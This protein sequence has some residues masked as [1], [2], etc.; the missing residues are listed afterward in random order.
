MIEVI[1][2]V[3]AIRN[4]LSP[5]GR[6]FLLERL[7]KDDWTLYDLS[8][9]YALLRGNE[10]AL[11]RAGIEYEDI[12]IPQSVPWRRTLKQVDLYGMGLG[13][14]FQYDPDIVQ[15]V[16]DNLQGA[17]W[18]PEEKVWAFPITEPNVDYLLE[19]SRYD[20]ALTQD[21]LMAISAREEIIDFWV[22][23]SCATDAD[24]RLKPGFGLELLPF[25]RAGVKYAVNSKSCII[26]D[27]MGTGKTIQSLAAVHQLQAFPLI[28]VCPAS[29]KINWLREV[30]RALPSRTV[31][32]WSTTKPCPKTDVVVINY[33]ILKKKKKDLLSLNAQGI[34]F[35]E[36]HYLKNYKAQ[37]TKAAKEIAWKIRHKFALSGTPI[38]SRPIE[39]V[40][41]LSII[42]RLDHMGGFWPYLNNYCATYLDTPYLDPETGERQEIVYTGARNLEQL[43]RQLR[44]TCFVRRTKAEVLK[45]L[46]PKRITMVPLEVT[47]N[48]YRKLEDDFLYQIDEIEGNEEIPSNEKFSLSLTEI[49][50]LKQETLKLK[51]PL[52]YDWIDSVLES[53]EKLLVFVW[54]KLGAE[55]L[56]AKYD[57]PVI[58]GDTPMDKRQEYVDQFQTDP[59]SRM[60]VMSIKA[61]G[62]GLNLTAA[63][64]VAFLELGWTPADHEQAEDRA[65][66]IGQSNPVN[67]WYL[68]GANTVDE[69]V[70]N[71]LRNKQRIVSKATDGGMREVA[72]QV[73]SD[74]RKKR[75]KTTEAVQAKL[76]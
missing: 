36:S 3:K 11:Q 19:I 13:M 33:D 76:F 30:E 50:K 10:T 46:P 41:Q 44:G 18:V 67:V 54:H 74:M 70:W 69:M 62:V 29:L 63:S 9:A 37:R 21:A 49:S 15:E 31:S 58:N 6:A 8:V 23:A 47:E 73:I 40:S 24:I 34:I 7:N 55:L 4:D 51:M 56:K 12:E 20:T 2:A 38:L 59:G 22:Q 71:V 42:D 60:L 66:R 5:W 16:K 52:V 25:Q 45:D 48:K 53:E 1:E 27:Q 75:Q 65:H 17:R 14:S 68:L 26:A 57:V 28:V 35:D 32:I 39:L 72:R 43:N 64:N 61:G